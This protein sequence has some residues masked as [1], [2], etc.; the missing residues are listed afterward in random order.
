MFEVDVRSCTGALH[1]GA[2]CPTW[3][4]K[5]PVFTT[6]SLPKICKV[7]RNCSAFLKQQEIYLSLWSAQWPNVNTLECFGWKLAHQC[8][9]LCTV[10]CI[11]ICAYNWGTHWGPER[12]RY[13][14][15]SDEMFASVREMYTKELHLRKSISKSILEIV[16]DPTSNSHC[17]LFRPFPLLVDFT[18]WLFLA[19]KSPMSSAFSQVILSF[20]QVLN[21]RKET[22]RRTVCHTQS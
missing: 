2:G 13:L 9:L 19:C 5:V 17:I 14:L 11:R 1:Q 15:S 12:S 10:Y 7:S 20:V 22:P 16:E 8:R 3:Q 21:L 18:S 6:L 4:Q